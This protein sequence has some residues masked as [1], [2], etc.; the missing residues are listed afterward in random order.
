[1]KTR[2]YAQFFLI[3]LVA[4]LYTRD[5]FNE[6][7]FY[8]DAGHL[9]LDGVFIA[10]Y[11]RDMFHNGFSDPMEYAIRYFG[12]YPALSI[13][14]KPP[15]WPAI[16]AAFI[17][18]FG[19][20][21]WVMRLALLVL[22]F[23]AVIAMYRTVERGSG[24]LVAWAAASLTISIPY[25]VQWGWYAMTELPAVVFILSAGW[26]FTRYIEDRRHRNLAYTVILLAAGV[27][28]K[29]TAVVG[30]LWMFI[31]VILT[32]G[33]KETF[34][35]REIWA[36]MVAYVLLI[37][38]VI[39]LTYEFGKKN[40]DQSVGKKEMSYIDFVAPQNNLFKYI[41][42]LFTHQLST[43]FATLAIAGIL[44]AMWR[45]YKGVEIGEKNNIILFFSL[46]LATY[47]FFTLINGRNPRYTVFW[48]PAFGFFAG[49]LLCQLRSYFA[50]KYVG[51]AVTALLSFNIVQSFAMLPREVV[52]MPAAAD[53][54]LQNSKS[55][56]VMIDSYINAHFIYAMRQKDPKR[57]F[58]VIRSDKVLS[59]S[60]I[61]PVPS[62]VTAF[63]HSINDIKDILL[64]HGIR[65]LV[66]E[67]NDLMRIPIHGTLRKYLASDEFRL[68]KEIPTS[69]NR[70]RRYNGGQAVQIFEFLEW[71]APT[72][73][74][75][76]IQVPIVGKTFTIPFGELKTK[77]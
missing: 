44:V 47:I 40:L 51:I 30:A 38:P 2:N 12:Q 27:W 69:S 46:I 24:P 7:L 43:L 55:K 13:G 5:M 19:V 39:I 10:D 36:A 22:A 42:A 14:Y 34:R 23:F 37:L 57:Q 45:L 72:S 48:L 75:I 60:D 29:Q 20:E 41:D 77:K 58:W 66:V 65:Y 17:L 8:P 62:N 18:L 56:V 49:Y 9:M 76:T 53:F 15:L 4:A 35:R 6:N 59:I 3:L 68:L 52:G 32:I 63:A 26:P 71:E 21:P 31:A 61:R 50:P 74:N 25:L 33:A 64:K 67:K 1:M 70:D 28:C 11:L 73:G 54:V 16:Q